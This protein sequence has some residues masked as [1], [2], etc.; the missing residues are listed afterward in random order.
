MELLE[1][2]LSQELH[3]SDAEKYIEQLKKYNS[4]LLDWN[5]KI[6][7]VSRSTT[8]IEDHILN[9]LFFL[10]KF[11]LYSNGR[12]ADIGTGGG[13]PGI[14]LKIL[15]PELG[16]TLID[17][18]KKKVTA[19]NDI[20]NKLQLKNI[21]AVCGRAEDILKNGG[22]NS[23]RIIDKNNFDYITAKAVAPLNKLYTWSKNLLNSKGR[24]LFIKGGDISGELADLSKVN[25]DLSIE[26]LEFSFPQEYGIEDKKL[27]LIYS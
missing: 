21:H 12:L 26:V 27:V 22:S 9:S 7:L 6:N 5:K 20:I 23:N 3:F 25:P 15:F 24:M 18:I 13:F 14:P 17:S 2:F 11:S 10:K 4:L 8:S 1:K 19:I 16:I